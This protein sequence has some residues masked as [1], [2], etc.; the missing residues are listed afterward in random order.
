MLVWELMGALVGAGFA[1][2]KEIASFFAQYGAWGYAGAVVAAVTLIWLADTK[3]PHEWKGTWINRLWSCLLAALLIATGGAMLAGAGEIASLLIPIK[4]AYWLGM[5]TTMILACYLA[6][7]TITGFAWVS[8][9]MLLVFG[10]VLVYGLLLPTDKAAVIDAHRPFVAIG[11]GFCYGGFNAA[12]LIPVIKRHGDGKKRHAFICVGLITTVLLVA[13]NVLFQRHPLLL[14]EPLPFVHLTRTL[15]KFGYWQSGGCL[16]L[17]ILSTL[18]ACLR[19]LGKHRAAFFGMII[20][21]LLGFNS[22][23]EYAYTLVGGACCLMLLAAKFRNCSARAF[24]S[25]SDML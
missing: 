25:R 9:G 24:I 21:A 10:V 7:H 8:K 19:G 2:G 23:V 20:I 16:Y 18:T 17:A 12:L 1:S 3:I 13:G 6:Y 4:G 5:A 14:H 15:G 11:R 22:V